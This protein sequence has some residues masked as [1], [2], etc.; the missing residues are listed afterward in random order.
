MPSAAVSQ[1]YIAQ[2]QTDQALALV[3]AS[4][5]PARSLRSRLE[6]VENIFLVARS[7]PSRTQPAS[8]ATE[9]CHRSA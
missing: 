2:L 1:I 9:A 7:F 4:I 3:L 8:L 5:E 6:T